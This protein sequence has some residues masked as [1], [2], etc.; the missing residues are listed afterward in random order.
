LRERAGQRAVAGTDLEDG[1]VRLEA[2]RVGDALRGFGPG[3]EV[4]AP[5][6]A[7]RR[8]GGRAP[9]ASFML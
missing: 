2:R 6:A 9:G 5:L 8:A 7:S 3:E 4:L 1:V